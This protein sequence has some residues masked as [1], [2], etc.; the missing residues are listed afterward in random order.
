MNR[1]WILTAAHCFVNGR[2]TSFY[3]VKL[4]KCISKIK[5]SCKLINDDLEILTLL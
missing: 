4:G 5:L 3:E 1:Q 2:N